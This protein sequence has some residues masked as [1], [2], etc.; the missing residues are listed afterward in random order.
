MVD[1]PLTALAEVD[2][3][4][5]VD[6]P[7]EV[8]RLLVRLRRMRNL[9]SLRAADSPRELTS[10]LLSM[11]LSRRY[12]VLDAPRPRPP[13]GALQPGTRLYIHSQLD[14]AALIMTTRL[15]SLIGNTSDDDPADAS[16]MVEWPSRLSYHERRRDY[17]VTVPATFIQTPARLL[18]AEHAR[19]ARLLDISASGAALLLSAEA[20]PLAIGDEVDC[21]LP[22]PERDLRLP[23]TVSEIRKGRD[24]QRIGGRLTITG[25][26]DAEL[27]QRSVTAIERWWLQRHP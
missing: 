21:V 11:D 15:D 14:G 17:R 20:L 2:T 10:M 25:P 16:L 5:V 18:I 27:L 22:L 12:L 26:Q 23:L 24:G 19:P 1:K 9:L 6:D 3:S 13:D 7:E 4:G 8:C